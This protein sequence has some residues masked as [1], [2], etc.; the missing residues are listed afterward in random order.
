VTGAAPDA[1]DISIS[2]GAHG[3]IFFSSPSLPPDVPRTP[4]TRWMESQPAV[5]TG[6]PAAGTPALSRGHLSRGHIRTT[7]TR[8]DRAS[9]A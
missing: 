6:H 8:L 7:S 2:L 9:Y 4:G 1:P 5:S 3:A